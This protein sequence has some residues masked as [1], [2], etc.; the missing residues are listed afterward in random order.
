MS[1]V[2]FVSCVCLAVAGACH[3]A[4]PE[5]PRRRRDARAPGRVG[6]AAR[7]GAPC[8]SR[9]RAP[10]ADGR[11]RRAGAGHRRPPR[12][13]DLADGRAHRHVRSGRTDRRRTGH[14]EDR[15]ARGLRQREGV[16]RH[17]RALC[18]R[19]PQARQPVRSRQAGQRRHGDRHPGAVPRLPPGLFLRGERIRGAARF[20]DRGPERDERRGRATRRSMR[21]T[22][23]GDSSSTTD[24][25]PKSPFQSGACGT[26]A[27]RRANR[28]A[29]AFRSGARSK[30]RTS[31]TS[32]R[33]CRATTRI[34][35]GRSACSPA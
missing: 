28:I 30:A 10:D 35:W 5:R 18:R 14:R 24:G 8:R 32:G 20:D 27:G 13:R 21:C 4:R 29:G 12:R 31:R 1:R 2:S 9:R 17:L 33:R 34:F 25:R 22:T 3:G 16:L 6:S 15:S 23:R 7:S 26:R 19:G 11:P